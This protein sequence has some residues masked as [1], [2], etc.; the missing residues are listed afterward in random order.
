M[1]KTW[2][3]GVIDIND[4]IGDTGLLGTNF[5]FLFFLLCQRNGVIDI[6]DEIGDTGLLGKNCFFIFPLFFLSFFR[7]SGAIDI[8]DVNDEIGDTGLLWTICFL[9]LFFPFFFLCQRNWVIDIKDE[10]ETMVFWV[11]PPPSFFILLGSGVMD[12]INMNDKIGDTDM[13]GIKFFLSFF[14]P[15]Y[16]F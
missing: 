3:S 6:N 11:R 16:F 8:S 12:M 13:L 1:P 4:E 14:F 9:F 7:C 2:R 15:S 10:L 5:F